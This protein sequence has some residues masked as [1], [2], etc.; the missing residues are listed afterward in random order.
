MAYRIAMNKAAKLIAYVKA[1][2]NTMVKNKGGKLDK[3]I[4]L[5]RF[6]NFSACMLRPSA[7]KSLR[8]KSTPRNEV[9]I[10]EKKNSCVMISMIWNVLFDSR[11]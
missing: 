5:I 10:A 2:L 6:E 11:I 1:L 7:R 3:R 8:L 4:S 9:V